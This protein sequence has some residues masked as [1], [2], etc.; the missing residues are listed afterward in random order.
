MLRFLAILAS[1]LLFTAA[2]RAQVVSPVAANDTESI[3]GSGVESKAE[4]AGEQTP[5]NVILTEIGYETAYDTDPLGI[6]GPVSADQ[7]QILAGN[8]L[9]QYEGS[10]VTTS[11]GYQPYYESFGR[12]S[13]Y[14]QFDQLSSADLNLILTARWSVRVRDSYFNQ[15]GSIPLL[16]ADTSLSPLGPPSSLNGTVYTPLVSEQ[17]NSARMDVVY[18]GS[19]RTMADVFEG[20]D[21]RSFSQQS[22]ALSLYKTRGPNAG[23]EYLW[24]PSE[25]SMLGILALYQ[26]LDLAG[27]LRAG[28]PS[29]LE[30]ESAFV[31]AEW[32]P[33][34]GL[35]LQGFAG[36][37][38]TG[39]PG[40]NLG[41]GGP[42]KQVE[43]GAGGTIEAQGRRGALVTS[44]SHVTTDGGGLLPFV[45]NSSIHGGLRR[46]LGDQWEASCDLDLSRNRAL[47][48]EFGPGNLT[49]TGASVG[50]ARPLS[51]RAMLHIEYEF[52][53]QVPA[54]NAPAIAEFHRNRIAT[55]IS[56]Q[57]GALSLGR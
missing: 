20:Y 2:I 24:R 10:R 1:A 31:T 36:P 56:W 9:L 11:I 29:R 27:T 3:F 19:V 53:R 26:G 17:E 55:G 22:S 6:S 34:G 35:E 41:T 16:A 40:S 33:T 15:T 51:Q 45:I 8:F 49:E 57:F 28:L 25:H 23:A 21:D 47:A 32:K 7:E 18:R 44:G 5:T 30:I 39:E 38:I 43:W 50:L 14:A 46:R 48:A 13:G 4:Y 54:G 42:S 12:N 52:I 37:Q